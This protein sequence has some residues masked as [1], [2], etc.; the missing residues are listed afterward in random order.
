MKG[1]KGTDRERE[2]KER[3]RKTEEK[4][5]EEKFKI[6]SSMKTRNPE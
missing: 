4:G 6:I 2:E 1:G 3:G 5:K